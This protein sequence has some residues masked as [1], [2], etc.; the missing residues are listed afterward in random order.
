MKRWPADFGLQIRMI[1]TLVLIGVIYLA[2]LGFLYWLGVN[3]TMLMI[4]AAVML[5]IQYFFSD[6]LVLA[7]TRAKVVT[8]EQAPELHQIVDELCREAG[9]PKPRVAVVPSNVPNA[10]ATGRSKR[11]SVIAVTNG[12]M[13]KLNL[14][15]VKAV[16]AHELSHVRNRDVAVITLAS[17]LSTIA[18]FILQSFMFGGM[19]GGRDRRN[20]GGIILLLPVALVV[21][22]ASLLLVRLLSR[23]RELAADRGSAYITGQPSHLI[24][25]L[26][27]ISGVMQQVP[28]RDLRA[29]GGG[30]MNQFY[31]IPQI[32]GR[33]IF[34]LF[35]THPSLE[36]R[37]R[38][39]KRMEQTMG[40]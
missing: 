15:E 16:L 31:I 24:N 8:P 29:G 35:S 28:T 36:R 32:R 4:I 10:F 22:F 19:Y 18:M 3:P 2:F 17:F 40:R 5:G 38:E 20:T 21:Y 30:A 37:I 39:L 25:A 12:L 6:K 13:Q 26:L 7:S 33:S 14:D 34:E 27:K 23:Y 9:L 1:L 11:H